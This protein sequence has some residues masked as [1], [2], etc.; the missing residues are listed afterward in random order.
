M[1]LAVLFWLGLVASASAHRM[2]TKCVPLSDLLAEGHGI[3]ITPQ[4]LYE[5]W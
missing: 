3:E 1:A 4:G 2:C 5:L